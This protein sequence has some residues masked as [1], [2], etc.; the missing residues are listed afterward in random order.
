MRP[1][2]GCDVEVLVCGDWIALEEADGEGSVGGDE[3]QALEMPV[4]S[5]PTAG[6]FFALAGV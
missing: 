3:R 4:W 5:P 2:T 6:A 1:L